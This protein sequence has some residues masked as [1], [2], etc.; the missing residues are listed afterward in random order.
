M[1]I[2][3]RDLLEE[4]KN[5]KVRALLIIL[6][7]FF[8]TKACLFVY[9]WNKQASASRFL[10]V[11]IGWAF[12]FV[13]SIFGLVISIEMT[14]KVKFSENKVKNAA[15]LIMVWAICMTTIIGGH[16][17]YWTKLFW[18]FIW[19]IFIFQWL[20]WPRKVIPGSISFL[21]LII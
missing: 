19:S 17:L 8:M 21:V 14:R 3:R 16:V 13:F 20:L 18:L 10:T 11:L 15:C 1:K 4:L 5:P 2:T 6:A 12:L 9:L 7:F